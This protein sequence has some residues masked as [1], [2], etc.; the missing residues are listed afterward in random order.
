MIVNFKHNDHSCL[1]FT[2]YEPS[3]I[4]NTIIVYV[5]D[6][7]AELGYEIIFTEKEKNQWN[8]F[9][10]IKM[11]FPAT[12]RNLCAQLCEIYPGNFFTRDELRNTAINE[13]NNFVH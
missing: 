11:K 12:Y 1:A 4:N 8:T 9:A 2:V 10:S 6:S 7:N 13:K 3:Q 5:L